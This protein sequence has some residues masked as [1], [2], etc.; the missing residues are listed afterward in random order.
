MK[1]NVKPISPDTVTVRGINLEFNAF[2]ENHLRKWQEVGEKIEA[3]Y[4][5]AMDL[6]VDPDKIA[7]LEDFDDIAEKYA[8]GTKAFCELF[9]GIFGEG[10]SDQ[11]FG[12]EPYYGLCLEVY[13]EFL[14]G[15]EKQG[16]Q[17]GRRISKNMASFAPAGP[18]GEKN[19]PLF[20]APV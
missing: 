7:G 18:K 8:Q 17:Y 16:E 3:K 20:R 9:D 11:L 15:I 10:T 5:G 2:N 14:G 1:A 6:G 13:Y 12:N 19:E 4:P